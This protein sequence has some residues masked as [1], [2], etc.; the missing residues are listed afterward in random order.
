MP[1]AG[2]ALS[3]CSC[4]RSGGQLSYW[5]SWIVVLL[6]A[7]MSLRRLPGQCPVHYEDGRPA[8]QQ[9]CDNAPHDLVDLEPEHKVKRSQQGP[10]SASQRGYEVQ[11]TGHS[12]TMFLR[13]DQQPDRIG[14]HHAHQADR[15]EVQQHG[16]DQRA[17]T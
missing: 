7:V 13:T 2:P 9:P 1:A 5:L 15:Q 4:E 17:I 8:P 10:Q 11:E 6:S 12:P 3:T 16:A 14:R